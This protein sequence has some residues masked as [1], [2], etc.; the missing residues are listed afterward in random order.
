MDAVIVLTFLVGVYFVYEY[1]KLNKKIPQRST[2]P[3]N[4]ALA[5]RKLK[6][7]TEI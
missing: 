6:L 3:L 4:S 1:L 5:Q 7:E 2:E